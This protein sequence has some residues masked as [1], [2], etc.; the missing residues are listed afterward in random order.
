MINFIDIGLKTLKK[1]LAE[2]RAVP[3]S[4]SHSNQKGVGKEE[5]IEF[6]GK[7]YTAAEAKTMATEM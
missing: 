5:M 1:Q 6:K 7:F 3:H 2:G 4:H